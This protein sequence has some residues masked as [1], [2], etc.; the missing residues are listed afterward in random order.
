MNTNKTS[1]LRREI[2]ERRLVTII[3][4]AYSLVVFLTVIPSFGTAATFLLLIPYYLIVPGYCVTL[5]FNENYDVLQRLLFSV[6]A[7]ISMLLSLSALESLDSGLNIPSPI[8]LPVISIGI[9]MYGYFF[10]RW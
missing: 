8:T 1:F 4:L 9:I 2:P 6:F 5:L 10:H 3:A 7:S